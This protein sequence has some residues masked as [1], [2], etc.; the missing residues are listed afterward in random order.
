MALRRFSLRASDRFFLVVPRPPDWPL[1]W[2]GPSQDLL[3]LSS[4]PCLPFDHYNQAPRGAAS[5]ATCV[6]LFA[7]S[8]S[9]RASSS[10]VVVPNVRMSFERCP[11]EST[12]SRH[13]TT[14]ALCTSSPQ[15]CGYCTCIQFH[16]LPLS[17]L[18]AGAGVATMR[19]S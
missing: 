19:D 8:Q 4:P 11:C 2:W 18:C 9:P 7:R 3:A 14:V 10:S 1:G 15:Q 17:P 5:S 16:L 6:A 12:S 13:A